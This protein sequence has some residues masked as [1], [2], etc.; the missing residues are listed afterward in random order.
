MKTTELLDDILA[1][2]PALRDNGVTHLSVDPATGAISMLIAPRVP[3]R[4]EAS[5]DSKGQERAASF[6]EASALGIQ[7]GAPMP[8]SFRDRRATATPETK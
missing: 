7:P 2:L 1:R 3:V 6:D 4:T 5:A 8:R